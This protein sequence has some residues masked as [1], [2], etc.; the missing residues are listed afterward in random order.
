MIK[1][2]SNVQLS[3]DFAGW[4]FDGEKIYRGP[5]SI[6]TSGI[7]LPKSL[8]TGSKLSVL[9]TVSNDKVFL[10]YDGKNLEPLLCKSTTDLT[11]HLI[12][13]TI[14]MEDGEQVIFVKPEGGSVTEWYYSV[15]SRTYD[16]ILSFRPGKNSKVT[17]F[18]TKNNRLN[19]YVFS[20]EGNDLRVVHNT[21]VKDSSVRTEG[22]LKLAPYRPFIPTELVFTHRKSLEAAKKALGPSKTYVTY[23]NLKELRKIAEKSKADGYTVATHFYNF[24]SSQELTQDQAFFARVISEYFKFIHLSFNDKFTKRQAFYGKTTIPRR[25]QKG[26]KPKKKNPNNKLQNKKPQDK[27]PQGKK[28]VAKK[29]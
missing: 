19:S 28:P 7:D 13:A 11:Y 16:F 8:S 10:N 3:D 27:K 17:I 2:F 26:F 4:E 24:E 6:K 23:Q 18:T 5:I 22:R 20:R 1:T 12:L 14:G 9:N 21:D 15:V 29:K 25:K